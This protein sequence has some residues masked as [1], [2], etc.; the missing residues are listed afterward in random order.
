MHSCLCCR[1]QHQLLHNQLLL[2]SSSRYESICLGS[3]V[4]IAAALVGGV[5][6]TFCTLLSCCCLQSEVH[7]N[8]EVCI[9]VGAALLAL[10]VENSHL[11]EGIFSPKVWRPRGTSASKEPAQLPA[12]E[13]VYV[14]QGLK[15]QSFVRASQALVGV[16]LADRTLAAQLLTKVPPMLVPPLPWI[17]YN[18]GGYLTSRW[19]MVACSL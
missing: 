15:Q 19:V 18:S 3:W 5:L 6:L 7:W 16:L 2:L 11:S 17:R 4:E 8:Q 1:T 10:L 14:K 12:F 9:K 13:Y